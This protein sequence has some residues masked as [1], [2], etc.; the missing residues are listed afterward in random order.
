LTGKIRGIFNADTGIFNPS[1]SWLVVNKFCKARKYKA[2]NGIDTG[3]EN[4][5][6]A[7]LQLDLVVLVA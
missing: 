3:M 7:L 4:H 5:L 1:L 2:L 6:V